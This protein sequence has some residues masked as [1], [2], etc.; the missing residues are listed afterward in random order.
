MPKRTADPITSKL[1]SVTDFFT[2]KSAVS[3]KK[4][5][6][7]A[8]EKLVLVCDHYPCNIVACSISLCSWRWCWVI[9]ELDESVG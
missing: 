1:T 2:P 4:A 3:P 9:V 8:E 6:T 7:I 5:K